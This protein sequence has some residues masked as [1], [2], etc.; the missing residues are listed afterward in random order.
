MA[1]AFD[2]VEELQQGGKARE[3][4]D[5][6]S[7]VTAGVTRPDQFGQRLACFVFARKHPY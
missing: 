7:E 3:W 6:G 1:E 2:A 5:F 4:Q